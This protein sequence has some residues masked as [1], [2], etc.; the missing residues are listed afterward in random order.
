MVLCL[1]KSRFYWLQDLE[2]KLSSQHQ[3]LDLNAQVSREGLQ[4]S[5]NHFNRFSFVYAALI[6]VKLCATEKKM[7]QIPFQNP[8]NYLQPR[9]L[10]QYMFSLFS[11]VLSFHILFATSS[12]VTSFSLFDRS[13]LEW[14]WL[15]VQV[16]VVNNHKK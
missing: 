14:L 10:S 2:I 8:L 11:S 4:T 1:F 3:T 16:A 12:F 9:R 15:Y 5:L 7:C 6:A 13:V